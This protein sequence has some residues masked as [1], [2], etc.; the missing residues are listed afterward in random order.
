MELSRKTMMMKKKSQRSLKW[1]REIK[2]R[3][4]IRNRKLKMRRQRRR[5]KTFKLIPASQNKRRWLKR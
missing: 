5:K 4:L 2:T 1:S 3:S